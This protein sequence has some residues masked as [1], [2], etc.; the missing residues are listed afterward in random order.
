MKFKQIIFWLL[1]LLIISFIVPIIN[2]KYITPK[3]PSIMKILSEN[4]T[5]N[6]IDKMVTYVNGVLF[7][8]LFLVVV[9]SFIYV[10][11][12]KKDRWIK[13]IWLNIILLI[14]LFIAVCYFTMLY[15]IMGL[16]YYISNDE[17][18]FGFWVYG[19]LI[20]L[21]GLYI[22][23]LIDFV[24]ECSRKKSIVLEK[25]NELYWE[26]VGNNTYEEIDKTW[27]VQQNIN[28]NKVVNNTNTQDNQEL[29]ASWNS[30]TADVSKPIISREQKE[31]VNEIFDN[32]KEKSLDVF[33]KTKKI[34]LIKK[35]EF[36]PRINKLI[37]NLKTK[38]YKSI[39]EQNKNYIDL[40]KKIILPIIAIVVLYFVW[41]YA[42]NSMYYNYIPKKWDI[43]VN[44]GEEIKY[45]TYWNFSGFVDKNIDSKILLVNSSDISTSNISDWNYLYAYFKTNSS[46]DL[47][48]LYDDYYLKSVTKELLKKDLDLSYNINKEK[49][50]LLMNISSLKDKVDNLYSMEIFKKLNWFTKQ[51]TILSM[52]SYTDQKGNKVDL[53]DFLDNFK[54]ALDIYNLDTL[55]FI[56]NWIKDWLDE[57]YDTKLLLFAVD[58]EKNKYN[59]RLKIKLL[60]DSD[61][62]FYSKLNEKIC[63]FIK[64]SKS[65]DIN[66]LKCDIG[67]SK[68]EIEWNVSFVL[69]K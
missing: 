36:S 7:V 63:G 39:L 60:E 62:K 30:E 19:L 5:S 68:K 40:W 10:N 54:S 18:N 24:K 41:M 52:V 14:S 44:K 8:F 2:S 15:F 69:I 6:S 64:V 47:K 28:P 50:T 65:D 3:N 17:W 23:V 13:F 33:K 25:S 59:F 61:D 55:N 31:K 37:S 45:L 26:Q 34:I 49:H 42:Y 29:L 67:V 46:K 11:N 1:G 57:S 53:S 9:L 20:S 48:K 56:V 32:V 43:L 12:W 38:D 21:L 22:S 4:D 58:K 51:N 16:H 66:K 27:E 35:E